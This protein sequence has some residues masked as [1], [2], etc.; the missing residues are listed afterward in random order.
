MSLIIG[1]V[2]GVIVGWSVPKPTIVQSIQDKIK[3]LIGK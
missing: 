3:G 1:L 2:V